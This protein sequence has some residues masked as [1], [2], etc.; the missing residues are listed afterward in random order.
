M[1]GADFCEYG[2]ELLDI[3][4]GE[5]AKSGTGGSCGIDEA[6]VGQPVEDDEI[7]FSDNNGNGGEG[8]GVA[9]GKGEGGLGVFGCG[10]GFL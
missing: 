7:A 2:G 1:G 9:R 6:G 10:N 8:G 5:D 4:V 3:I